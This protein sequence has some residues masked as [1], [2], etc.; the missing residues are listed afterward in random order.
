MNWTISQIDQAIKEATTV[1]EV[2]GALQASIDQT[3]AV[4]KEFL[5]R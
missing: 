1:D 5:Q 2:N 4:V 3:E